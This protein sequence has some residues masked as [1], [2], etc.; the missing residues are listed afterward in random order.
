M[1]LNNKSENKAKKIDCTELIDRA[2]HGDKKAFSEI[3][4]SYYG[5]VMHYLLSHSVSYNDAEDIAQEAFINLFKKIDQVSNTATFSGW[6]LRIAHNLFVDKIRKETKLDTSGSEFELEKLV[7]DNSP[8]NIAISNSGVNDVFS[9]LKSRERVILE[10]RVFQGLPFAEIAE[11]NEMTE[12][13]VRIVFHRI[14]TK[15]RARY[16]PEHGN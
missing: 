11:L 3:I 12:G 7:S 9:G 13:N 5:L 6:L 14:I 10:L 15:L 1:A 16:S 4:Q 8:E 2:K